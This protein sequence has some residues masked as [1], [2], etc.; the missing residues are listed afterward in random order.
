MNVC[1]ASYQSIMMLKG[2]PG[3]QI[4]QTKKG[5]EQLG[6]NVTYL[7]AWQDF[8]RTKFDL[9]HLF[10]A[11]IGTYHLAREIHKLGVPLAV[12]PIFYSLHSPRFLHTAL[13]FD[14]LVKKFVSGIWMDYG[15]LADI[16]TWA[17][18]ILP[19]TKVEGKLIADG[20]NI[21]SDKIF[22][23]PNGVEERF[24]HADGTL[25]RSKYGLGKFIL[26]VGHTGPGRKNVLRLIRAVNKI[27]IPAVILG[28]IENNSYGRICLEEAK[29]GRV[30][31]VEALP[32]DSDLLASAY[33]ACD[34]FV[35]PSLF[36]TPGIAA[37][38]A[39]LAGAKIVITQNGGTQEY[40]G[41]YAGYVDPLSVSS[42]STGIEKALAAQKN[43]LL[44]E[45]IKKEFLWEH[46]AKKTLT[47][48]EDVLS[49][50][51]V[52]NK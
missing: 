32:N 37:L 2:G 51:T 7:E 1:F 9:I 33:A 34:T 43:N 4:V 29:R 49:K 38:E 6:V 31:I 21:Q 26:N 3:T 48:Y 20:F 52:N 17:D 30:L 13:R 23:V 36:E 16:C 50:R 14:R 22:V 18:V 5:L 24:Y 25:F 42:I 15:L 19:N 12:T 28:R 27:G 45:Q 46:V 11:H 39:A 40:F 47:V 10:G 44:R 41:S 8:D 35:L